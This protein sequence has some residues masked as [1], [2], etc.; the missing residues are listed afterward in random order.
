MWNFP[1]GPSF[2]YCGEIR[3]SLLS[4]LGRQGLFDFILNPS[5]LDQDPLEKGFFEAG[6]GG[7]IGEGGIE[8]IVLLQKTMDLGFCIIIPPSRKPLVSPIY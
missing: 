6:R 8:K 4:F 7:G 3:N 2:P 1:R 5:R